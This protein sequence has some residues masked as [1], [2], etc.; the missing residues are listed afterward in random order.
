MQHPAVRSVEGEPPD[1]YRE[2]RA[3]LNPSWFGR[4]TET[5]SL[6]VTWTPDPTPGPE[7]SD[8]ANDSWMRTPI[9]A[10]YTLHYSEPDGLDCG[11][12]CEPNPHVDGFLHYQ[13]REDANDAYTYELVSFGARSVTGLLWEMLDALG[14]RLADLD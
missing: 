4:G 12:H 1:E 7:V 5:A 11:F 9:R 13:K 3:A 10:Y 8:R 2:L 6:R 14:D